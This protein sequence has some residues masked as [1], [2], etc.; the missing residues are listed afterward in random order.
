MWQSFIL[1]VERIDEAQHPIACL[2]HYLMPVTAIA[3]GPKFGDE[4]AKENQ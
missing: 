1:P 2:N 4:C 3:S